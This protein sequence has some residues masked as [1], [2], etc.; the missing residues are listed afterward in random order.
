M[1]E[2]SLRIKIF[3]VIILLMALVLI[4]R[5]FFL[6]IIKSK[7][8]GEQADRQY[9]TPIGSLFNRGSIF[10]RTK[11]GELVAAASNKLGYK[12]A[13]NPKQIN[14]EKTYNLI[15]ENLPL[16]KQEFFAK[17][18]KDDPYEEIAWRQT[19][20]TADKISSWKLP[21]VSVFKEKW[22]FYPGNNL[23]SHTIGF[24]AYN[25]DK[26]AGRYGLERFYE[27]ILKREADNLYVNFFA[28]VFAN[29]SN[30]VF[31][32]NKAG[33]IITSIEPSVQSFLEETLAEIAKKWQSKNVGGIILNPQNG[34]IYA[35][36][37]LP[38]F[39]LNDFS[40]V[41]NVSIFANPLVEN[42]FEYGSVI[43]PLT[44]A[45]AFNEGLITANT[46]YNDKGFVVV[47]RETLHN[48]D[49][50]GRGVVTM[51][52]VLNQSLN[53]GAVFVMQK[54]GQELFRQYFL[55]FGVTEKTG[56]DLPNEARNLT[57]L[58]SKQEVDYATASFGQG[59]ALTPISA[60]RTFSILANGGF[61]TQPHLVTKINYE[62][63]P[64]KEINKPVGRQV[65]KTSTT[66][67]I[68]RM[69]VKV[70]ETSI[71]KKDPILSHYDIAAKTGTAQIAKENGGGYYEDR[72]LHAFFGYF[73]AYDPKFLVFLYN[74]EPKGAKFAVETL[75]E[76]FMKIAK[77][78]LSFYEI[79]PTR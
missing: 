19:K 79:P 33:D 17:A 78:L 7:T 72:Y 18:T 50:K 71:A 11:N 56:I 36:A 55:N 31:E 58:Q 39:N 69:L 16:N 53:T 44:L 6:Q 37:S 30:L 67:E 34:E 52:D 43:K 57:N 65:L 15:S 49:K 12:I 51:Q 22:R 75:A 54:L 47:G 3:S 64:S 70:F 45:A 2:F 24:V 76:P 5:L 27:D 13:I 29:L 74:K 26:L 9:A 21:G 61:L 32:K 40:K 10:F 59:L 46:K 8:Y 73:P 77:F 66:E 28:E 20:E 14:P 38:N 60:A 41:E 35:L 42:V 63:L 23:A 25:G 4:T 48:F 62:G 68:T 1:K